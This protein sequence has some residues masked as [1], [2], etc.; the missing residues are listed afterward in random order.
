MSQESA[1]LTSA[2]EYARAVD[3]RTC[4]DSHGD[5]SSKLLVFA[6]EVRPRQG[7][8]RAHTERGRAHVRAR[9]RMK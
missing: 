5:Q 9:Q 1:L 7:G 3:D 6:Y 8:A 2:L 4:A